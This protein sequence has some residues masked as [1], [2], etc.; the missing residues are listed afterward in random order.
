MVENNKSDKKANADYSFV[1]LS[2]EIFNASNWYYKKRK[3]GIIE[4]KQ[5]LVIESK[6]KGVN[7]L[8]LFENNTSFSEVTKSKKKISLDA[9]NLLEISGKKSGNIRVII[10]L[11][12]Y[13]S[14]NRRIHTNKVALNDQTVIKAKPETKYARIAIRILGKGE[15]HITKFLT[16]EYDL[17][18]ALSK[19]VEEQTKM[20]DIKMACIFDEFSMA[21]FGDIVSLITF[22]PDDW[23]TRFKNNKPDLL[24]I[25]SAWKGNSGAWEYQI[26]KY[27]NNNNNF[28]LKE[29]IL[30]C[31]RNQIPTV[32]WNKEDPIHF[33]KFKDAAALVDYVFTTDADMIPRY[34]EYVGHDR[35][36]S[37]QFAANPKIHNPISINKIKKNKISFAGSYYANRHPDRKKDMDDMLKVSKKFGLDIFDRNFKRN[38]QE[39]TDFMFPEIFQ[40]NVVGTLKYHE[41]DK[42]Y[43]DYRLILN[44]NSVKYSPTMFSR[45]VFEGL[46]CGTPIIS[47]YS[48]GIKKTFH[49]IV[50]VTEEPIKFEHEVEKLMIDNKHY[51]EVAMT[52]MREIFKKHTYEHRMV[53]ILETVG[54]PFKNNDKSI[55][56]VFCI[57]SKE[58]FNKAFEIVEGQSYANSKVTFLLSNFDGIEELLNSY[59]TEQFS[60]YLMDYAFKYDSI[61]EL[62]KTKFVTVMDTDF[63]YGKYYIEDM[64]NAAAF[65][66]ADVVGKKVLLEDDDYEY[67]IYEYEYVSSVIDKTSIFKLDVIKNQHL[68]ELVYN[69]VNVIDKLFRQDGKQIFS[70]DKFNLKI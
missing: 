54:V 18:H 46:A 15:L 6:D 55:T 5:S 48:T 27:S 50:R 1:G 24:M 41:M 37:M 65:S 40:E 43:K 21:S 61:S 57:H 16:T 31:K 33:D 2:N 35:V 44:V 25:E 45:R 38:Q 29:L 3:I 12:E 52:G 19:I 59:N 8:T 32:F 20:S 70:A 22:S 58:E 39:I 36:S 42:A 17:Q 56:L 14:K 69:N 10:Y 11:I 13:D 26:G 9:N 7:Y 34:R 64:I 63:S 51:R 53:S 47:S 66:D 60:T 68:K 28:K 4:E 62:I 23:K 49:D 30:W 67:S